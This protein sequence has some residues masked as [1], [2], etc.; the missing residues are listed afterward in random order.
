MDFLFESVES[1]KWMASERIFN[2]RFQEANEL[3]DGF[4]F[5][6]ADRG[7]TSRNQRMVRLMTMWEAISW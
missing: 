4:L 2:A 1:G 7:S 6:A 5:Q 3:F